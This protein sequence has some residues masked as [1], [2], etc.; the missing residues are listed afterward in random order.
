[1]NFNTLIL[2][3]LLFTSWS[4][5]ADT[6]CAKAPD[7]DYTSESS[8][9][10]YHIEMRDA[11]DVQ[12]IIGS[13][14]SIR[15]DVQTV[16]S[17]DVYFYY[18]VNPA[19]AAASGYPA[20][21]FGE[22]SSSVFSGHADKNYVFGELGNHKIYAGI[23]ASGVA[24]PNWSCNNGDDEICSAACPSW[25]TSEQQSNGCTQTFV[26][27]GEV[28]CAYKN[29]TVQSAPTVEIESYVRTAGNAVQLFLDYTI[30][31]I[32][33]TA[34]KE[35]SEPTFSY[36]YQLLDAPGYNYSFTSTSSD[37]T[38]YTPYRGRWRITASVSDGEFSSN[39]DSIIL[40]IF[41]GN[42]CPTCGYIP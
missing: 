32:Y 28:L 22:D 23:G 15:V 34:A 26:S 31:E 21:W 2:F 12:T 6:Y 8:G 4:V 3:T 19:A 29:Y 40:E 20:Q 11:G 18:D 1:M 35:S 9:N 39:G 17:S 5:F 13:S 27:V 36:L 24:R 30:D 42:S 16:F 37:A 10:V 7:T 41:A 25:S 33:S 14:E 38:I